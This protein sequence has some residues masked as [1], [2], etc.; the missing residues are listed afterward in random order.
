VTKIIKL[1]DN[2]FVIDSEEREFSTLLELV[3]H[4]GKTDSEKPGRIFLKEC[5]PPSD[6][7]KN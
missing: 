7:G 3:I 2:K 4:C 6:Y 5:L 1:Q